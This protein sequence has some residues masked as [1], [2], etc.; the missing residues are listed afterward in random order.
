[1]A[2]MIL[3]VLD[4]PSKTVPVLEAWARAGVSGATILESSGLGRALQARDDL[5][6]IP[7][8]RSVLAAQERTHRTLFSV[9]ADAFDIDPLLAET[10]KV[11]GPLADPHTGILII[12]PVLRVVGLREGETL[13]TD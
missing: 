5:P 4:D 10:E 2:K 3:F 12:L 11:T 13:F 6:L 7:S 8:L 1:M 9:L